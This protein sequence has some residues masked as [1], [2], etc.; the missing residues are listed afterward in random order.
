MKP[1]GGSQ[2]AIASG[3]EEGAIDLLGF[4]GEHA[5][6]FYGSSHVRLLEMFA[7]TQVLLLVP[8][9]HFMPNL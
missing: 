5:M 9:I 8:I 2:R 7:A 3:V 6:Q 4:R 1:L